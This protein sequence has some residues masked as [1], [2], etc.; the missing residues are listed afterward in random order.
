MREG[1][2][3]LPRPYGHWILRLL[4]PYTDPASTCRPVPSGVVLC[5]PV[6]FRRE[7]AVSENGAVACTHVYVER[8]PRI[9]RGGG[10]HRHEERHRAH[11]ATARLVLDGGPHALRGAPTR[12]RCRRDQPTRLSIGLQPRQTS[13][14]KPRSTSAAEW[15][16]RTPQLSSAGSMITTE[17]SLGSMAISPSLWTRV[18]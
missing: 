2:V 18:R 15:P 9:A 4:Q 1:R 5:H 3:E 6:S 14:E 16:P 7:Q 17:T 8:C 10:W 13:S 11:L 12:Q